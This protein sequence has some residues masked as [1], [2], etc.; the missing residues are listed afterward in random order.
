MFFILSY[1]LLLLILMFSKWKHDPTNF[2]TVFK[3]TVTTGDFV[4]K[5]NDM[6]DNGQIDMFISRIKDLL[7]GKVLY[8]CRVF[9]F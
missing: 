3:I 2:F 4:F 1:T 6:A 7:P 9:Y 8:F 5:E